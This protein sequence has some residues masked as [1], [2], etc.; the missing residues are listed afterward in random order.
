MIYLKAEVQTAV[1]IMSTITGNDFIVLQ[2]SLDLINTKAENQVLQEQLQRKE[3]QSQTTTDW[4]DTL[5]RISDDEWNN[6][7]AIQQTGALLIEEDQ[8][9]SPAQSDF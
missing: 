2:T 5:Q 6:H 9:Y 3:E 1:N 4:W 8:Y 7:D